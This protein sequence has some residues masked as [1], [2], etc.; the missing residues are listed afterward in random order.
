MEGQIAKFIIP[1]LKNQTVN[2]NPHLLFLAKINPGPTETP[3][4]VN[5]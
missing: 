3:L 4:I 2:S 1:M 5:F